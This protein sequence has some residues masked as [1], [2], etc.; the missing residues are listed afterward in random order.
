MPVF[1]PR[2]INHM[3]QTV[4]YIIVT[5]LHVN[6]RAPYLRKSDIPERL[7][8]I[9][10]CVSVIVAKERTETNDYNFLVGLHVR[11]ATKYAS[12]TLLRIEFEEFF[13]LFRIVKTRD[14]LITYLTNIDPAALIVEGPE[15]P[16]NTPPVSSFF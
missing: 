1:Y 16:R 14:Y 12:L 9:F 2:K 6:K 5:L 15:A 10:D 13:V 11:N 7:F 8:E 3:H 4:S